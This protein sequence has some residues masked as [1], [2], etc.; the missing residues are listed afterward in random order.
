VEPTS[1][2]RTT[3]ITNQLRRSNAAE[4]RML[5]ELIGLMLEDARSS[6]VRA[7]PEEF[8]RIQGGAQVLD[9]L[10]KALTVTP[11]TQENK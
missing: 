6:L 7:V 8:Q 10:Y 2:T 9:K 4:G 3:E 1:R 5:V 11:P